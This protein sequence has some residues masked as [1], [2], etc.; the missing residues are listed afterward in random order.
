MLLSEMALEPLA[1]HIHD[2]S[3]LHE[4]RG[5]QQVGGRSS[6]AIGN[7][8]PA[9]QSSNHPTQTLPASEIRS[10]FRKTEG[11]P[12]MMLKKKNAAPHNGMN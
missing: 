1:N 3:R 5:N 8:I 12:I 4:R 2:P 11:A 9:H 10:Y 7:K 6:T